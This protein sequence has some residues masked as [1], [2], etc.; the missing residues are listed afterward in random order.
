MIRTQQNQLSNSTVKTEDGANGASND[1]T[2][3][4]LGE[5]EHW[6]SELERRP[7]VEE[8]S[9]VDIHCS[10]PQRVSGFRVNGEAREK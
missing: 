1:N 5:I 3:R 7:H 6:K 9:I 2:Q 4:L 8:V 10:L